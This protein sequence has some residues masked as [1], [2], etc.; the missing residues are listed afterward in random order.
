MN[1]SMTPNHTT[2][3]SRSCIH[4]GRRKYSEYSV[5]RI[6]DPI[7]QD[8]VMLFYPHRKRDVILFRP[9]AQR[10]KEQDGF[11]KTTLYQLLVRVL[12]KKPSITT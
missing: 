1:P 11:L 8:R 9:A 6:Q 5:I 12:R 10:M 2:Y 3:L 4:H 7:I